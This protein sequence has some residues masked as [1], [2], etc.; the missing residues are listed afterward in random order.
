MEYLK[1]ND[2]ND[3]AS[4]V[5]PGLREKLD[6]PLWRPTGI[7]AIDSIL[8]PAGLAQIAVVGGPMAAKAVT[9]AVNNLKAKVGEKLAGKLLDF[10]TPSLLKKPQEAVSILSDLAEAIKGKAAPAEPPVAAPTPAQAAPAA[11]QVHTPAPAPVASPAPAQPAPAAPEAVS[12]PMSTPD[13]FRSALKAFADAK[14]VPRPAEVNNVQM[15]IKRG[16]DPDKAL[17][18][19]LGNRPPA[20]ANPAAELAKRLG[21][22]SEAEMNADMAARARKGQKSLMP[23]Y[24]GDVAPAP[25]ATLAQPEA[26]PVP[27]PAPTPEPTLTPTP[28]PEPLPE[29]APQ[30]AAK[31]K[32]TPKAKSTVVDA[33]PSTAETPAA[34]AERVID[35]AGAKTG[36]DVQGRVVS[37]LTEELTAAQDAAKF[38]TI[39]F[40][41]NA[42][43]TYGYGRVMVDGQPVASVDKYGKINWLDDSPAYTTAQGKRVA[44]ESTHADL[45]LEGRMDE[46]TPGQI[47]REATAKVAQAVGQENGAGMLRVQIPGDG[48]FTVPR[49]PHAISELIRRLSAGGPSIWQGVG[50]VKFSA[51]KVGP[52]IP[53]A[54]W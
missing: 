15:L 43:K 5:G 32:R 25:Q 54:T 47:A 53:K 49:N 9:G 6:T 4:P 40:S 2:P 33:P 28:T 46:K 22:P 52:E 35:V 12:A 44:A 24:G 16:V 38:K 37:A 51:P 48:T 17:Q 3:L 23:K 10:V 27:A 42:G 29:Q 18:T 39:E 41:P 50:D 34:A 45:S 1:S 26:S 36:K 7:D 31:A 30:P 19:V 14:E 13:A 8:S 21:T 11:P 20:P